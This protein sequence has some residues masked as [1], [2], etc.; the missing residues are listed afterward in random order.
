MGGMTMKRLICLL[1]FSVW[2][3][4][5][6]AMP[7]EGDD[8]VVNCDAAEFVACEYALR[9]PTYR[10]G[11]DCKGVK[12]GEEYCCDFGTA[13]NLIKPDKGK[14]SWQRANDNKVYMKYCL[15][16]GN[17]WT[18]TKTDV[19]TCKKD[20]HRKWTYGTWEGKECNEGTGTCKCTAP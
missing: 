1:V 13:V 3:G 10:C 19:L 9:H 12:K 11:D 5:G 14:S 18:C 2:L 15:E 20:V 7:E 8:D 6:V 16:P 17:A 4:S